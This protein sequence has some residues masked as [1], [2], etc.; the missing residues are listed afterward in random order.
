MFYLSTYAYVCIHI[1]VYAYHICVFVCVHVCMYTR[2]Y[3]YVYCLCV[4]MHACVC[5][6]EN[7]DRSYVRFQLLENGSATY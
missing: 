1:C 5:I 6:F 7:T 3:I 2:V 4:H